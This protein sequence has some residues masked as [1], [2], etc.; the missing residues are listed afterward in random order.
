MLNLSR[1]ID[2]R[3]FIQVDDVLIEIMVCDIEKGK[4]RL[5]ITAPKDCGIW[6]EEVA[7][8]EIRQTASVPAGRQ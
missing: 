8:Y 1:R 5:G 3:L 7:P 4:V 6:R 2:E